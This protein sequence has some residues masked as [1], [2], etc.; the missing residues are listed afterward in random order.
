VAQEVVLRPHAS[1]QLAFLTLAAPSRQEAL[2]LAR[3]YRS[4][5]AATRVF[6]QALS[7]YEAEA[8]NLG[9]DTEG[10]RH[11]Q[12]LLSAL[13][14]PN[15]ALRA[16]PQLLAANRRGQ[17]GLWSHAISGDYPILLVRIKGRGGP[18]PGEGGAARSTPYWRRKQIKI[19][20][21]ILNSEPA[22]YAQELHG[23]LL[24]LLRSVDA[25]LWVNRRGGIFV[26]Q[27]GQVD[28]AGHVL[29]SSAAR[30]VLD[31][32]RCS[33]ARQIEPLSERPVSLPNSCP[34]I[35]AWRIPALCPQ[36]PRPR[37]PRL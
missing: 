15:R 35:P 12:Q 32:E 27:A 3:R 16:A 36:L 4:L 34:P 24:S 10:L 21:V 2:D 37:G 8:R 13:I 14:Y 28:E 30:V 23:H 19:D 33:L 25:D 31:A 1:V 22:G 18:G 26:L 9:L 20:L 17:P 5:P 29:L 6:E 11:A 7:E